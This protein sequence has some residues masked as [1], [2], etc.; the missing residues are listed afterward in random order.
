M[1]AERIPLRG[2]CLQPTSCSL[3][4]SASPCLHTP[5]ARCCCPRSLPV[6]VA[7]YSGHPG[8]LQNSN[9]HKKKKITPQT[10]A[11][12]RNESWCMG[13]SQDEPPGAFSNLTCR[14]EQAPL[15][16]LL[17][18]Q[19]FHA[20]SPHSVSF[21]TSLARGSLGRPWLHSQ[22]RFATGG[23][24]ERCP[25]PARRSPAMKSIYLPKLHLE[26]K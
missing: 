10:L 16:P 20:L 5:G 2:G 12:P 13:L 4:P 22:L 14:H 24:W 9:H 23:I 6:M 11:G 18:F 3:L 15:L 17:C 26:K 8:V 7:R 21:C 25:A 19:A 1:A